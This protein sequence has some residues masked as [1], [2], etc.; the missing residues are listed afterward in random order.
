M[1]YADGLGRPVVRDD[2]PFLIFAV[3]FGCLVVVLSI[4]T[5]GIHAN[6]VR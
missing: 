1:C 5:I 4:L 3:L 2:Q 6:L